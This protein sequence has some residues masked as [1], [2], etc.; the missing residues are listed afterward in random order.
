M[1]I[2]AKMGFY[3]EQVQEGFYY[4]NGFY[5]DQP[6]GFY[7]DQ[8]D[9]GFNQGNVDYWKKSYGRSD[10]QPHSLH[11]PVGGRAGVPPPKRQPGCR[12]SAPSRR[13]IGR[14]GL[15]RVRKKQQA[16]CVQRQGGR[17]PGKTGRKTRTIARRRC[18][19]Q[20][21]GRNWIQII[22]LLSLFSPVLII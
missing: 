15:L 8:Q 3:Y 9:A 18:S 14:R 13:A 20:N 16:H 22:P 2:Q 21:P 7:Y 19:S 1:G 12:L 17:R 5:Y 4:D 6:Q 11:G 10:E